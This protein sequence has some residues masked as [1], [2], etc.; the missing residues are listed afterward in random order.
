MITV[1]SEF[2]M[3]RAINN[4]VEITQTSYYEI[5]TVGLAEVE[6]T[7]RPS[8]EELSFWSQGKTYLTSSSRT[9]C[10]SS[11]A[12]I[13]NKPR[14]WSRPLAVNAFMTRIRSRDI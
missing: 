13:F 9:S 8:L 5:E 12:K 2:S 10:S 3:D 7:S 11:A 1:F 6:S 4:S 14:E